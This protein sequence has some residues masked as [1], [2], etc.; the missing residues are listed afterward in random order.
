[1]D[2]SYLSNGGR[3]MENHRM[4]GNRIQVLPLIICIAIPLIVGF[5]SSMLTRNVNAQ[6]RMMV[7]PPLAP[8][9]WLFPIAWTILYV[10]M[11]IASYAMYVSE[12][13]MSTIFIAIYGIQL[14]MNFFWDI[15]FF[16]GGAYYFSF[17]WLLVMW[18]IILSLIVLCWNNVRSAS[19]FLIP[20]AVWV[21]YA[22]YLNFGIAVLN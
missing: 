10:L 2:S 9:A 13:V 18:A 6:Y 16:N 17:I 8:P 4:E 15:I 14:V 3:R 5:I 12:N 19:Y 7:K 11:G 22:A 1:M 21:T 20:Y